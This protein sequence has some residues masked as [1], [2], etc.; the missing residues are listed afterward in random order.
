ML[1]LNNKMDSNNDIGD[2][3]EDNDS[4]DKENLNIFFN[5]EKDNQMFR[6]PLGEIH[7]NE[8]VLTV[9]FHK[10]KYGISIS[11]KLKVGG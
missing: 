11:P 6:P 1:D 8:Q 2:E 9:F 10:K 5:D 7:F 4:T 3:N